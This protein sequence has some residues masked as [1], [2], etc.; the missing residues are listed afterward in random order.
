MAHNIYEPGQP[1]K[2]VYHAY[3]RV[4]TDKQDIERQKHM[5]RTYLNGGK[6]EVKWYIDEGY[7]GR[8]PFADRPGLNAC[9]RD[10]VK[11]KKKGG[12]GHIIIADFS[13]LSRKAWHAMKFFEEALAKDKCK[14]IICDKPAY[15]NLD[16]D[17]L[18]SILGQ[19]SMISQATA[20]RL[21]SATKQ[22]LS[23]INAEIN[24]KGFHTAKNGRVVYKLG[25]HENMD[26]A[27]ENAGIRVSNDADAFANM[28]YPDIQYRLNAG[29]SYRS[30]AEEFNTRGFSTARQ[31]GSWYASTISKIVKRVEGDK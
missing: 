20:E 19:E 5:I 1:H 4:S 7:S 12:K 24:S 11:S 23:R 28:W 9:L 6:H 30:I 27:R 31:G 18:I 22:G 21:S 25:M 29:H 3:V 26:K 8:M 16:T 13:R 15:S 2:G 14:L 17:A 10:A